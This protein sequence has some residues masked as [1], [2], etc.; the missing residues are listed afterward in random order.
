M[1]F[2]TLALTYAFWSLRLWLG[3]RALIAGVEKFSGKITVQ[4]P[5]LDA[6]GT[7]DPSGAVVEV[8]Q[9]VYGFAH[10][11][12]IPESL[13]DKF[14]HEPLLP[15]FLTMPFYFLLG[16]ILIA[17]GL[18]V[19]LGIRTREALLGMAAIFSMLTIGLMLIGQEQG[20][21][22][23]GVHLILIVAALVLLPYNRFSITRS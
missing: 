16:Y 4:Q 3:L 8:D 11:Q 21:A 6:N 5:L 2:D 15:G 17:L 13:Q 14:A 1:K 9:K 19:L 20:V 12:S 10:Y 7:P 22:W 23:L 18:A